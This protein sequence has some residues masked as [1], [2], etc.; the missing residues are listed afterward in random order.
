MKQRKP[1]IHKTTEMPY[2][3]YQPG[4]N[5]ERTRDSL[6]TTFQTRPLQG[7]Q[8]NTD[9]QLPLN[10]NDVM[11]AWAL[12]VEGPGNHYLNGFLI[13]HTFTYILRGREREGHLTPVTARPFP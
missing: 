4:V 13:A 8:T 6:Q 10:R 2:T 7:N 12:G 3:L 11:R 9:V 5:G 1:N